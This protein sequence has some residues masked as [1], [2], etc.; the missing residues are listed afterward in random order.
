MKRKLKC[1]LVGIGLMAGGV[2]A[3][4]SLAADVVTWTG[5]GGDNLWS[6]KYNWDPQVVP[7]AEKEIHFPSGNWTVEPGAN[8]YYGLLVLDEGTGSVTFVGET[9]NLKRSTSAVLTVGSGRE[10]IVDGCGF[11]VGGS[12]KWSGAT[13]RVRSG[14]VTMDS[15]TTLGGTC[16]VLVEGGFFGN[17]SATLNITNSAALVVSGGLAHVQ[18]Y[19]IY[20]S[21][22]PGESGGL[23]R[24][25]GG[26]LHNDDDYAYRSGTFGGRFEFLGGT[27][28]WGKSSTTA[29]S[30]LSSKKDGW[31]SGNSGFAGFL[32]PVRGLLDIP[33]RMSDETTTERGALDFNVTGDYSFGGT[34][35]V[36]N[37]TDSIRSAAVTFSGISTTVNVSGGATIIANAMRFAQNSTQDLDFNRVN[38]GKGGL[39]CAAYTQ[40]VTFRNGIVFG[41]WGDW[42]TELG[43]WSS[44]TLSGPVTFDTRDCLDGETTHVIEMKPVPYGGDGSGYVY[45]DNVTELKAVG[46]GSVDL[47][48]ST[49]AKEL[50]TV[51]VGDGTTL[52]VSGAGAVLKAA[53]VSLGAN[54]TLKLDL[55]SGGYLDAAATASF[56]TG[57]KI[58]ITKLPSDLVSGTFYPICMV[59]AKRGTDAYAFPTFELPEGAPAGWSVATTANGAYLTDGVLTSA[60]SGTSPYWTGLGGDNLFATAANWVSETIPGSSDR[61][62]FYG[63]RNTVID[64]G[65]GD[66]K[67]GNLYVSGA[68]APYVFR[69]GNLLLNYPATGWSSALHA[70]RT[71]GSLP[72]VVENDVGTSSTASEG[73]RFQSFGQGSLSVLG[74]SLGD[75][76]PLTFGG[77]VRLG[78][79]WTATKVGCT[80]NYGTTRVARRSSLAVMPGANLTV[81]AQEGSQLLPTGGKDADD[82]FYVVGAGGA[83]TVN[84]T[85]FTFERA[86]THFIDGTLTVNCPLV[87]TAAQKFTG[88]G[89]L[90]F[91]QATGDIA[92]EGAL[93]LVPDALSGDAAFSVRGDLTLAPE[94]DW[95][96]AGEPSLALDSHSKLTLATGGRKMTFASPIVSDIDV[97]VTGGGK[98]MLGVAGTSLGSVSCADGA[99][100]DA[101]DELLQAAPDPKGFADILAVRRMDGLVLADTLKAK[102]RYESETDSYVISAKRRAGLCLIVR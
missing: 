95:S 18:Q 2:F 99:T 9:S 44:L 78:G 15:P 28:Q 97:A 39:K 93:T 83:M 29:Q 58:V 20:G 67:V 92:F 11:P 68:T 72:M 81:A 96:Y 102:M 53:N 89:T 35:V 77:D 76:L 52:A 62:S 40:H 86:A 91:A 36:T 6:N 16:R 75:A 51:E 38:L 19:H 17:K 34:V 94:A 47:L 65:T 64:T 70:L 21:D 74:N 1:L 100:V 27:L 48:T 42:T 12:L 61:P 45:I 54:A 4:A 101:T 60:T 43:K 41:A 25:T 49:A 79:N 26:M 56:G 98:F 63:T 24:L 69:G 5:Q 50:R 7:D 22:V 8:R 32:P 30:R 14:E 82:F 57:A 90:K 23:V 85:D 33:T 55:S 3:S 31:S 71:D 73:F 80:P 59:P 88:N 84:G 87:A 46:G 10:L 37:A 13:V 66:R